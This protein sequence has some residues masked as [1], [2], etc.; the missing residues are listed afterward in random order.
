MDKLNIPQRLVRLISSFL[1][2]RKLKVKIGNQV[3][4]EIIMKAGTPQGSCLSPL[5]YII[6]V[7]DI[8][9]VDDHASLGQFAD[10]IALWSNEYTF[11]GCIN[12][13]QKA[14]NRKGLCR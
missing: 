2:E 3:S 9:N 8:P 7:N 5:L 14:V 13:L 6:L 12:R 4:E 1:K 10:D 11:K